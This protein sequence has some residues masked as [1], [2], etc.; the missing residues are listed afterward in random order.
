MSDAPPTPDPWPLDAP[1]EVLGR[2]SPP[3][4]FWCVVLL[5]PLGAGAL[6]LGLWILAHGKAGTPDGLPPLVHAIGW[7]AALVLLLAGWRK[8]RGRERGAWALLLRDSL[9]VRREGHEAVVLRADE[10]EGYD[11]SEAGWVQ[12]RRRG[13][14]PDPRLSIPTPGEWTR[15]RVLERLGAM[16]V[17]ELG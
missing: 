16:G 13:Q 6:L 2:S 7:I 4:G 8:A 3:R 5:P 12:L 17:R 15:R 9:R 10:L 1:I 11:A 14:G